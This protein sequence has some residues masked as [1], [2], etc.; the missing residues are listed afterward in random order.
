MINK[1]S[2]LQLDK[3]LVQIAHCEHAR[4]SWSSRHGSKKS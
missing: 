2:A 3:K 4:I 1:P